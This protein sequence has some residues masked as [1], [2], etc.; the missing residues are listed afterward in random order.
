MTKKL[1]ALAFGGVAMLMAGPALA[2]GYKTGAASSR[3]LRSE[4]ERH[5]LRRRLRLGR[6]CSPTRTTTGPLTGNSNRQELGSDGAFGFLRIGL[7]RQIHS[8]FV[9]GAFADYRVPRHRHRRLVIQQQPPAEEI[10]PPPRPPSPIRRERRSLDSTWAIGA[11]ARLRAQLLRDVVHQRRLHASRRR[12]H[13]YAEQRHA[14][15]AAAT[16]SRS[17]AGSL[18]AAS[19]SSWAR[20]S[21]LSMEYR[22]ASYETKEV[23]N[24]TYTI[25]GVTDA[26]SSRGRSD[27]PL[28]A[29][30]A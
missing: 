23:F 11:E 4:L 20:G 21:A 8:G 17:A 26:P 18:A 2:D 30:W 19:S 14:A 10:L 12:P 25:G 29:A 22:Y 27:H 1:M 7:D 3:L 15:S 9:L 13:V 6:R 24:G 28:G 5:L 16:T